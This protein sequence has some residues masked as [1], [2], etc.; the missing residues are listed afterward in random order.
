[1][2][3]KLRTQGFFQVPV[4]KLRFSRNPR[5]QVA[6]N[7]KLVQKDVKFEQHFESQQV[8]Y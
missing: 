3:S 5:Q 2:G 8:M 1:M 7:E 4:K 6:K